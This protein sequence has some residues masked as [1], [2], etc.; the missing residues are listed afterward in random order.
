MT[1]FPTTIP[2]DTS[3]WRQSSKLLRRK[4][5]RKKDFLRLY[6]A[7]IE[8]RDVVKWQLVVINKRG[9][10]R[11]LQIEWYLTTRRIDQWFSLPS[12]F[13]TRRS[14]ALRV[15]HRNNARSLARSLSSVAYV[16]KRYKW[17][18]VNYIAVI[19][20]FRFLNCAS[21]SILWSCAIFSRLNHTH[22]RSLTCT[23]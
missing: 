4:K 9:I 16:V 19:S 21:L 7:S 13:R 6:T 10:H 22:P 23:L 2:T 8:S 20:L 12:C 1:D 14:H 15:I 5:K 3:W 11:S 18:L 17:K